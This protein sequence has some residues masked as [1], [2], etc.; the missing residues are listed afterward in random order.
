MKIIQGQNGVVTNIVSATPADASTM[1]WLVDD[2][3]VVS[4]GDVFDP[5]DPEIDAMDV[6]TFRALFRHE[7]MIRQLV[8]AVRTNASINTAATTAGLPTSAN[9]PDLTLPQAR[10]AFKSL[11][12]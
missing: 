11:L 12:P 6:G 1:T 10:L 3:V 5:K 8:R 4:V 9:A 2:S 7:N